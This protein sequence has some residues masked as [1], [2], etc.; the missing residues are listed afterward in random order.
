MLHTINPFNVVAL[1]RLENSAL[2]IIGAVPIKANAIQI[3]F[4]RE[5]ASN[6]NKN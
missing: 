2:T 6:G 1:K 4:M 5:V 3:I